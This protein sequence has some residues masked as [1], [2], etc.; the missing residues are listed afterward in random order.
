ME[1]IEVKVDPVEGKELVLRT[2][3]AAEIFQYQGF[4]Y[5]AHS[6]DSLI[7]LAIA[8]GDPGK[9]VIAYTENGIA[10]ILD[11]TVKDRRQDR[12]AYGFKFSQQYSEWEPILKGAQLDQ[13]SLQKFL[14]RREPGEI[15]EIEKLLAAVQ[16]LKFAK[17]ISGDSVITDNNNYTFAI[18]VGTAESTTKIPQMIIVNLEIFN[19]S[20]LKQAVEIEVEC[21]L[22]SRQDEKVTFSFTC[23]KL[24]RYK[25]EA[26]ANE[27]D[28]VKE[29]LAGYLIITGEI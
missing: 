15:D 8:K 27:V 12:I 19:E 2:G 4:S 3:N 25:R 16:C 22:P 21:N 20:G 24:A 23:P 26:V 18:Q 29:A 14:Q 28:K 7:A 17:N 10:V 1:K 9:S 6:T 13:R 11:D 5:K